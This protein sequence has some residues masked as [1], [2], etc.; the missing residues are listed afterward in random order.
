ML[1]FVR[2][3]P[4]L[5]QLPGLALLAGIWIGTNLV[6]RESIR[7]R[8]N[9]SAVL[10]MIMYALVGGLLGARLLY[11]LEHLSA[12]VAAPLSLLALSATA[13][14]PWGG[15]LVGAAVA[16][17]YGRA[18][19]LPLRPTLDALAPGIAAFMI[20]FGVANTLSGNG[21]GSPLQKPWAIHLW[22]ESRHPTQ[23][24]E[25]V[26]ALG[27]FLGWKFMQG[28]SMSSGNRFWL[29]VGL[30]AAARVFTEAF[31]GDS[32]IT[33]GGFRLAQLLALLVLA[34]TLYMG[35]R[36]SASPE[37]GPEAP[38]RRSVPAQARRA[39]PSGGRKPPRRKLPRPGSAPSRER[40]SRWSPEA[41]SPEKKRRG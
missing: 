2:I 30:S 16:I 36:W 31:R 39:G 24:Y 28:G 9:A 38:A 3:G 37:R 12:Y 40:S 41:P 27:V 33:V 26:L 23:I 32:V 19:G 22:G 11:A 6:E 5:I 18:R 25:T 34:A 15:L 13:L 1:P 17:L 7:L 10:N 29:V 4:L 21:Y 20:A 8:L 14:D 35:R